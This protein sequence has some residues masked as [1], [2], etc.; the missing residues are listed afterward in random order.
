MDPEFRNTM[1]SDSID[2]QSID[3]PIDPFAVN[4]A[5][6][7]DWFIGEQGQAIRSDRQLPHWFELHHWISLA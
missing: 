3:P 7:V 5:Y 4:K 1:R 2:N 6:P